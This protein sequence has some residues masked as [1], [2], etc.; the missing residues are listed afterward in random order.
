MDRCAAETFFHLYKTKVPESAFF[1]Y[2]GMGDKVYF[3]SVAE[4]YGVESFDLEQV[5][6]AFFGIYS[7]KLRYKDI[8]YPGLNISRLTH[9]AEVGRIS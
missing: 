2:Q 1:P 8:S 9:Y 7:E 3:E 5:K 6:A 4:D